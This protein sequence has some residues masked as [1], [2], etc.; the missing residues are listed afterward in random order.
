MNDY[1][2]LEINKNA[3]LE[4]I[5][6]SYRKLIR[7]Y[8]PDKNPE[9]NSSEKFI[10]INTAYNNLINKQNSSL[11]YN[12]INDLYEHGLFE[13]YINL[14]YN[15]YVLNNKKENKIIIVNCSLEE[16]YNGC[17]KTIRYKRKVSTSFLNVI[18]EEKIIELNINHE[19]YHNQ[20]IIY[21]NYG[22]GIEFKNEYSD[23]VIIIKEEPHKIY[24]RINND[25]LANINLNLKES[26]TCN[27]TLKIL[28]LN[29]EY[30]DYKINRIIYPGYEEKIPNYGFCNNDSYGNL[31]LKFN[32]NFP[33][34]LSEQQISVI[35]NIL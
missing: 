35:N 31:I 16:I 12:I 11:C 13:K 19:N 23:V 2:I 15:S 28:L 21:K 24:K 1:E 33:K 30:L 6:E 29:D 22:D 8:H 32:I 4:T 20:K 14:L 10:K 26:L 25:L 9:T 34:E 3:D 5:K 27:T 7:K 17:L 18:T